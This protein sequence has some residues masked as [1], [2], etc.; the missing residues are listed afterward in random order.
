MVRGELEVCIDKKSEYF[1]EMNKYKKMVPKLG[2]MRL[3]TEFGSTHSTDSS[4]NMTSVSG[5]T[6]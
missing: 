1:L 3:G 5:S 2:V 6:D 4:K